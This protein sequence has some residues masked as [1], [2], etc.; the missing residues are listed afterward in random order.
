MKAGPADALLGFALAGSLLLST[1]SPVRGQGMLPGCRL[2]N[3]SL[4]CVP[5]LT[6]TPQQQIQVLDGEITNDQQ[7][8]GRIVEAIKGLQ[9]FAVV[10][11]A[12]QKA[13]LRAVLELDDST[14]ETVTIHWY[15]RPANGHW[16]LIDSASER[17]YTIN[18]NDAGS[19]V[20][21]VL[22]VTTNQG[23]VLKT[24]SNAVGPIEG[25]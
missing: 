19:S 3:G 2:E 7:T 11:E 23:K 13:L 6:T 24:N 14:I 12:K 10:G 16:Q 22:T 15:R 18:S 9:R 21:A 1:T 4:Q 5:G 8:E 25:P 20:M 17:T